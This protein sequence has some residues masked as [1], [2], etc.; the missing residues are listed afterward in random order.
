MLLINN[1]GYYVLH[2]K[3]FNCR[4][5]TRV[6]AAFLSRFDSIL[7]RLVAL[8]RWLMEATFSVSCRPAQNW[9]C[10]CVLLPSSELGAA[11]ADGSATRAMAT[12]EGWLT[13]DGV[14]MLPVGFRRI[15][16]LAVKKMR[17]YRNRI[18]ANG[19]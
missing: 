14:R 7:R 3:L 2:I 10:C 1:I 8:R 15:L 5:Y 18:M 11:L 9:V 4:G 6:L 16:R 17:Q 19:R 12:A 13:A